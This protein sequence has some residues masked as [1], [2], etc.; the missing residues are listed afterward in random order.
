MGFLKRANWGPLEHPERCRIQRLAIRL[1]LLMED[2]REHR[3]W[4]HQY[5]QVQWDLFPGI[6][7]GVIPSLQEVAISF[8]YYP[9]IVRRRADI[10]S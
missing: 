2:H 1:E 4:A 10:L 8:S 6:A 5:S 3:L 7:F 9:T